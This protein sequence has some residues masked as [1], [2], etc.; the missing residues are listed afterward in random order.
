MKVILRFSCFLLLASGWTFAQSN[1]I[2][3]SA[4]ATF[5]SDQNVTTTLAL[6]LLIP[7]ATPN[8]NVLSSTMKASTAFTFEASYARRLVGAGPVALFVE[9][10]MMGTPGHNVATVVSNPLIGT[11]NGSTSSTLFFFT[12]S[13]RVRFFSSAAISP[14]ISAGGGWARLTQGSQNVNGGA[15]QFGGGADFRTGV[16]HL[17]IRAELRDFWS[18]NSAAIPVSVAGLTSVVSPDHQH[19]LFAGG[20]VV[21]R[22]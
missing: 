5:T 10:P 11:F 16:P 6:P 3:F 14:W 13:A 21:L 12:P 9:L 2:S 1:E 7:C 8:C 17:G 18:G 15:V 22:F 4:G 20:G 19:H